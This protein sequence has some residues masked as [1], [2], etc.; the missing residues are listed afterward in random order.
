MA[1]NIIDIDKVEIFEEFLDMNINP[2]EV[3]DESDIYR[4]S[5]SF[6][7]NIF[8]NVYADFNHLKSKLEFGNVELR[9]SSN[10]KLN[11]ITLVTMEIFTDV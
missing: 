10:S 9:Y 3:L 5:N 7:C 8:D 1:K 6:F 2:E 4:L 11:I